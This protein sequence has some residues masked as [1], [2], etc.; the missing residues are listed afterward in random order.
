MA[1]A[2]GFIALFGVAVETGMLMVVYLDEAMQKMV[3]EKGASV[4]IS[5]LRHYVIEGSAKRLRPKLMTVSVTLFGLIPILWSHGTG[6]DL[7]LPIALPMIGGMITS[8]I[9]VLL[10]TP[11]IFE[12]TKEHE[13]KKHGKVEVL[14]VKH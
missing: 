12:M 10:V 4:S 3:K 8:T 7:M 14:N 1:V 5:E 6:I 2:V 9:H 13:L 11:I